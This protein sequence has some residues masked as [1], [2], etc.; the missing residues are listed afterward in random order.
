MP[1][2]MWLGWTDPFVVLLLAATW[3]TS[4]RAPRLLPYATGLLFAAKQYMVIA[5]PLLLLIPRAGSS[6]A[7]TRRF[8]VT[9]TLAGAIVTL[10]LAMH[11]PA[12][13]LR[14]AALLQFRQ[15]FRPDALSYLAWMAPANPGPWV[16]LPFLVVIGLWWTMLRSGAGRAPH[17]TLALSVVAF[18][19][20]ALNK[21]AFLNYYCFVIGCLACAVAACQSAPAAR[22]A[23]ATPGTQQRPEQDA[24]VEVF[25]ASNHEQCQQERCEVAERAHC[26]RV[27]PA[28]PPEQRGRHE[29]GAE[30]AGP[31]HEHG[32]VVHAAEHEGQPATAR[33][34]RRMRIGGQSHG[35]DA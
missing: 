21:Q 12:G 28:Q 33:P 3:Y 27:P 26:Q 16:I 4:C 20:F 24:P 15:P 8:V 1:Q 32:A 9:A 31:Q 13:F 17:W 11:D 23:S 18:A 29:D 7:P 6:V 14:S 10:P 19:F 5:L 22:G 30:P 2:V 34:A 35:I 25:V